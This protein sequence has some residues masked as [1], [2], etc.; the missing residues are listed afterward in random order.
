MVTPY[1]INLFDKILTNNQNLEILSHF[2]WL[3]SHLV[4]EA[5]EIRDIILS[6]VL[7]RKLVNSIQEKS[8]ERELL[9]NFCWMFGNMSKG[10]PGPSLF[11]V[12]NP[13]NSYYFIIIENGNR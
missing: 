9:K 1:S 2:V 8:I 4:A 5:I 11:Q 6:S 12:K 3:I 10:K 7:Y 13:F